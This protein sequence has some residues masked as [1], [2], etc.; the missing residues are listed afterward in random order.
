MM[1]VIFEATG[2]R[3]PFVKWIYLFS[4]DLYKNR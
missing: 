4:E 3:F 1:F 2:A